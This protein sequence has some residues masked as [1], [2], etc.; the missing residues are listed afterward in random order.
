MHLSLAVDHKVFRFRFTSDSQNND[1]GFIFYA[2]ATWGLQQ[3]NLPHP[4]GIGGR[5]WN[6][7]AETALVVRYKK[8]ADA[9]LDEQ[10]HVN[11]LAREIVLSLADAAMSQIELR[12]NATMCSLWVLNL[13]IQSAIDSSETAAAQAAAADARMRFRKQSATTLSAACR[14][15]RCSRIHGGKV[16]NIPTV[17]QGCS[18]LL[19]AFQ[20]CRDAMMLRLLVI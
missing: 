12:R 16:V 11:F 7:G 3:L 10:A 5:I 4:P 17:P 2:T 1:F 20:V 6:D 14:R 15:A 8:W 18:R 19:V 13:F 9:P